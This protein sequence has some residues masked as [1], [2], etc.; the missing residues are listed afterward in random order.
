MELDGL[1]QPGVIES[2]ALK[3]TSA[4]WKQ[5]VAERKEL[6]Q[7][8]EE[9]QQEVDRLRTALELI[10]APIR[11][12]GTYNRD[13]TACANLAREALQKKHGEDGQ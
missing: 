12:D 1:L 13:R 3:L 11:P 4:Q 5:L 2:S 10:A 8:L 9:S 7:K 6:E